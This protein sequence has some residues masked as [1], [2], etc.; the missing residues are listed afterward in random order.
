VNHSTLTT[1]GPD[2]GH[3]AGLFWLMLTLGSAIYLAVMVLWV[4]ALFRGRK[5]P[6][7]SRFGDNAFIL[8]GGV[9]LPTVVLVVLAT[10]TVHVTNTITARRADPLRIEV[11]G[12]QY[13]WQIAYPGT[14]VITANEL[15]IPVGRP[16]EIGLQAVDVD[17]SFWVPGLAGKTDLLPDQHNIIRLQADK[18]G[19]YRGQCAEFCGL[20][21]AHMA[22]L[23]IAQSPA[24]FNGW[25]AQQSQATLGAGSEGRAVFEHQSCAGCH[26]IRGTTAN[27]TFGP[28]LTHVASRS[29][30]AAVTFANTPENLRDW[31]ADAQS[32]K[33]GALM[34]ANSLS[35]SDLNALVDYLESLK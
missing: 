35:P 16:V 24:A 22:F 31:I 20:Q 26:T 13:W 33:R 19:T 28:D 3:I 25:L 27:G 4:T 18:A 1:H 21:H 23:V 10:A 7:R 6:K 8:A 32:M 9:A 15:H 17:H 11:R 14:S 12:Y 5:G 29:T 34:P 2:A 30:L